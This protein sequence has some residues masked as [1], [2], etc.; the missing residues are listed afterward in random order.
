MF[1]DSDIDKKPLI[2]GVPALGLGMI[3]IFISGF[4]SVEG[5]FIFGSTTSYISIPGSR[6]ITLGLLTLGALMYCIVN[7]NLYKSNTKHKESF[8]KSLQYSDFP[9]FITFLILWSTVIPFYNDLHNPVLESFY[10]GTIAFQMIYS[11][12]VWSFIDDP[13]IES[14]LNKNN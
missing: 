8:L 9:V 3:A 5:N 11:N 12:I 13:I 7:Y 4:A 6:D 1:F 10:G 2:A 14:H